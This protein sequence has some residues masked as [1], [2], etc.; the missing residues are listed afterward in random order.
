MESD[1]CNLSRVSDRLVFE[2]CREYGHLDYRMY[3]PN[4]QLEWKKGLWRSV[5]QKQDRERHIGCRA[6]ARSWLA[7]TARLARMKHDEGLIER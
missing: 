4:R 5:P 1:D 2:A 7:S 3:Q 6:Q